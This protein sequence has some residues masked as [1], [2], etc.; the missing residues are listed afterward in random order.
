M[1]EAALNGREWLGYIILLISSML[2]LSSA[3]VIPKYKT[4]W[5]IAIYYFLF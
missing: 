2:Q 3:I 1:Y 5:S 4:V